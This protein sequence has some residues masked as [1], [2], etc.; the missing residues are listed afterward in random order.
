MVMQNLLL[1]FLHR[2]YLSLLNFLPLVMYLSLFLCLFL[3]AER[4]CLFEMF[5]QHV[6]A[7]LQH[8]AEMFFEGEFLGD[9]TDELLV[10]LGWPVEIYHEAGVDGLLP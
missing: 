6:A 3:F 4:G 8:V 7:E 9:V 10:G 2:F 1:L 5:G